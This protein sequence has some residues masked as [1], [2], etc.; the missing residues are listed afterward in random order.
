[1]ARTDGR[2]G[3]GR[4]AVG[5]PTFNR[6]TDAVKALAALASDPLVLDVID[7]VIMPDQGTR[8]VRD[9]P[10]FAEAA[11]ILGDRLAIHDQGNLAVPVATAASCTRR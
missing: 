2:S 4:V 3:E 8:K 11:A 6:P 5:I 10:G 7:A 1:M 9:E